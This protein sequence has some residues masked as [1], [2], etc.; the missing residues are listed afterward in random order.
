MVSRARRVAIA[1]PIAALIAAV[2]ATV[3]VASGCFEDR[4]RCAND[5]DCDLGEGGRCELDG[6]CTAFDITCPLQRRYTQHAEERTGTCFDDRTLLR[7][8]CASGQ[9]PALPDSCTTQVCD[10]LPSCCEVGWSDACVQAAQ[11]RC[12]IQCSTQIAL[13]ATKGAKTELWELVWNGTAW[14]AKPHTDYVNHLAWVGPAPGQTVPRL[15]GFRDATTLAIG[16][17]TFTVSSDRAY[18]AITTVDVDRDGRDTAVLTYQLGTPPDHV[19]EVIKVDG[20]DTREIPTAASVGLSWGDTNRDGF[21]DGVAGIGGRY[22]LLD[23]IDGDEHR[24]S[25]SSATSSNF[26]GM[27][28]MGSP[29]LR[30]FD[31]LDVDRDGQLDLLAFGNSI[32]VHAGGDAITDVALLNL[33]CDPPGGTCDPALF[34]FAGAAIPTKTNAVLA[35]AAFQTPPPLVRHAFTITI[36]PGPPVSTNITALAFGD[37]CTTCPPIIAFV[38]RDIDGDH[39]LDLIGFDSDLHVYTGLAKNGLRLDASKPIDTTVSGFVNIRAT[40][41]GAV[42]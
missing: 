30:N 26:A 5:A 21:P 27:A 19:A 15:A 29:A 1:D 28:T 14:V 42:R 4:Y 34:S 3:T 32:R 11:L 39:K 16:D 40:V 31:W 12:T 36:D 9:P 20:G 17:R 22:H 37:T 7:N 13:T 24:R 33:D 35:V 38:V 23:N 8:P 18:Q 41:S 25:L 2:I 10:A 6:H